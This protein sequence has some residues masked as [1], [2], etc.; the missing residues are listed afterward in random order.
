MAGNLME[1]TMT[2]MLTTVAN[3]AAQIIEIPFL[4]AA[5]L[6]AVAAKVPQPSRSPKS[7]PVNAR[8]MS[9]IGIEPGSI[10]WFH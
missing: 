5:S 9:D 2:T 6:M 7:G 10:T 8:T 1:D 3:N 4:L